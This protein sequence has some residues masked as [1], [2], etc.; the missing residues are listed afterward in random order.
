[1]QSVTEAAELLVVKRVA[2]FSAA[3]EDRLRQSVGDMFANGRVTPDV[4]LSGHY[5]ASAIRCADCDSDEIY[6]AQ[7]TMALNYSWHKAIGD[8]GPVNDRKTG[9]ALFVHSALAMTPS[10]TSL[11]LV[12]ARIWARGDEFREITH[13]ERAA[14]PIAEKESCKWIVGQ[15]ECGQR[16]APVLD[17]GKTA[18]VAG[19]REN[20]TMEAFSEP[21][22]QYA[23]AGP[24]RPE[25]AGTG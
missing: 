13:T 14:L 6:V 8:L 25:Q 10:G 2:P 18:T 1:M 17:G 23:P 21:G 19:D 11:G 9:K 16:L 4:V 5:A 3:V 22:I 12:S 7:D 24:A 15:N 20:D